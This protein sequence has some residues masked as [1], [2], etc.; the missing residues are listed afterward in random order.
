MLRS[1]R[2]CRRLVMYGLGLEHAA[3]DLIDDIM[4]ARNESPLTVIGM[5]AGVEGEEFESRRFSILCQC[6]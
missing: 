3:A 6:L 5:S 2:V 1:V 4:W